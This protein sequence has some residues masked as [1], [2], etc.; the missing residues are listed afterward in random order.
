LSIPVEFHALPYNSMVC[1]V[2]Y[3]NH[4]VITCLVNADPQMHMPWVGKNVVWAIGHVKFAVDKGMVLLVVLQYIRC[5][6]C[7]CCNSLLIVLTV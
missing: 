2:M 6:C 7:E 4:F 5:S 1:N 3:C